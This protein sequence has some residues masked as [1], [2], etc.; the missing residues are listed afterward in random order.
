MAAGSFAQNGWQI[1]IVLKINC[2]HSIQP[3]LRR[4]SSAVKSARDSL[5]PSD[6]QSYDQEMR[7]SE[8]TH[9]HTQTDL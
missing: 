7:K 9:T 3:D 2:T 8:Q 5:R 4:Y 6:L 1:A